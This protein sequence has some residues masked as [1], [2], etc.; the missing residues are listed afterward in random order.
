MCYLQ[1]ASKEADIINI[2]LSNKL[3]L[4]DHIMSPKWISE[5]GFSDSLFSTLSAG[6]HH[7]YSPIS[8]DFS[9]GTFIMEQ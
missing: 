6:Q 2:L 7:F 3:M 5:D 1:Q 9:K 4:T 8:S